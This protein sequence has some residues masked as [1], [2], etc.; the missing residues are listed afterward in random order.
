VLPRDVT[1]AN[2]DPSATDAKVMRRAVVKARPGGAGSHARSIAYRTRRSSAQRHTKRDRLAVLVDPLAAVGRGLVERLE[3][4]L[5]EPHPRLHAEHERAAVLEHRIDGDAL[6]RAVD[7]LV[8]TIASPCVIVQSY[9]RR[10]AGR[11]E[12]FSW[13]LCRFHDRT[14]V[15]KVRY[16]GC[17]S[18]TSRAKPLLFATLAAL[19]CACGDSG[20]SE[21]DTGSESS[22]SSTTSTTATTSTTTATTT[23]TT[24]TSTSDSGEMTTSP[25]SSAGETGPA[26]CDNVGNFGCTMDVADTCSCYGCN[27]ECFNGPQEIVSDCVCPVCADDPFCNQPDTCTDDGLCDPFPEGCQCSDC[28][29]HPMCAG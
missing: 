15:A 26:T 21:A 14:T 6:D 28:A 25:D 22:E 8:A 4:R 24:T 1:N 7:G 13:R 18:M 9:G 16:S 23:T 17:M 29:G 2:S 5:V 12:R 20:G 11:H 10:E 27:A 3:A 19:A